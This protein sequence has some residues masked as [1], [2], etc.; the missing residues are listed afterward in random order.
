MSQGFLLIEIADKNWTGHRI[1]ESI[2]PTPFEIS[3]S[4]DGF[5]TI[6]LEDPISCGILI[7]GYQGEAYF[8]V[9]VKRALMA[10]AVVIWDG[11][12]WPELKGRIQRCFS[13]DPLRATS[14]QE[15]EQYLSGEISILPSSDWNWT[16][17]LRKGMSLPQNC[18]AEAFVVLMFKKMARS[19]LTP[20]QVDVLRKI[21]AQVAQKLLLESSIG[22]QVK[23]ERGR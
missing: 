15:L 17:E 4:E 11:S 19:R 10:E 6:D 9:S 7:Q 12:R 18:P 5:G 2:R 21:I 22:I 13:H 1:Q 14:F 3:L 16:L 23:D 20:E 8:N